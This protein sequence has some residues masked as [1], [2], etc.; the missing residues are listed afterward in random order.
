[1]RSCRSRR[2][3]E[4]ALCLISSFER[5]CTVGLGGTQD[6]VSHFGGVLRGEGGDDIIEFSFLGCDTSRTKLCLYLSEPD[7]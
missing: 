1:M 5:G 6:D 2:R 7:F 4:V 3:S